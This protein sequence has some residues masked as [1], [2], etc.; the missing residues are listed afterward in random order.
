LIPQ[1]PRF[2]VLSFVAPVKHTFDTRFLR[3][4]TAGTPLGTYVT[5]SFASTGSFIHMKLTYPIEVDNSEDG[6]VR[7][8]TSSPTAGGFKPFAHEFASGIPDPAG[9]PSRTT[10]P[11]GGAE[12]ATVGSPV[13]SPVKMEKSADIQ[14]RGVVGRLE[15][16]LMPVGAPP[17]DL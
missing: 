15:Y 16:Y 10:P 6:T 14:G 1:V 12:S 11:G 3:G 2:K 4:F 17:E 7:L 13:G 8:A 5:L 9:S